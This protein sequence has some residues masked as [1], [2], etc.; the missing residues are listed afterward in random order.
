ML[1]ECNP[2]AKDCLYDLLAEPLLQDAFLVILANKQ[3]QDGVLSVEEV[4]E[5][6][7]LNSINDREWH[8]EGTSIKYRKDPGLRRALQWIT[9][10][11]SAKWNPSR[12][13]NRPIN[14]AV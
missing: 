3:D 9:E 14:T 4:I 13:S 10:T 2:N 7:D 1:T 6:L 5:R 8:I 11:L 12:L